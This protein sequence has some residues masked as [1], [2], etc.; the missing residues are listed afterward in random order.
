MVYV[1]GGGGRISKV[2]SILYRLISSYGVSR[3]LLKSQF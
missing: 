2:D 1:G 3:M